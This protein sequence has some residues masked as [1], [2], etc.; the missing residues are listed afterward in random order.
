M[1]TTA[2]WILGAHLLTAHTTDTPQTV[3]PGLYV[4]APVGLTAG[5]VR[6]SYGRMAGYGAWTWQSEGRL[7]YAITAG[8]IVGYKAQTVRPMLVPSMRL[9]MS[10][11]VGVRLSFLPKSPQNGRSEALTLS[12]ETAF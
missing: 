1:S 6:N 7:A 11:D 10:T 3:T 5:L 8:G 2:A 12:L 4:R 9:R